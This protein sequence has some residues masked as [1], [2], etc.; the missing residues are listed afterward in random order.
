MAAHELCSVLDCIRFVT[1]S[2]L[3]ELLLWQGQA[4]A[5]INYGNSLDSLGDYKDALKAYKQAYE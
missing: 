1:V 3:T 2:P 5:L 4:V